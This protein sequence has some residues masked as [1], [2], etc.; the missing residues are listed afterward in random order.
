M[1]T[2]FGKALKRARIDA[3]LRL[4]ALGDA[5]GYSEAH[6]A[7]LEKDQRIASPDVVAERFLPALKLAVDS[8][9][10]CELVALAQHS[11]RTRADKRIARLDASVSRL[12]TLQTRFIGRARES[13][14]LRHLLNGASRLITLCGPGG[15]G[16]TRLAIEVAQGLQEEQT[17]PDGISFVE[18]ATLTADTQIEAAL[19][20]ALA[21]PIATRDLHP[22][23]Y[24]R[25]RHALI[26]F[27]NCEQVLDS[28]RAL[29]TR[30]QSTC[31]RVVVL[32]TSRERLNVAHET[33]FDVP[34]LSPG[35]AT[36]LYTDRVQT[37]MAL[38]DR[39]ELEIE[40]VRALCNHL[41][42][43]PLAIELAASRSKTLSPQQ[44]LA[45]IGDNRFNVLSDG[46]RSA[47]Q[48]HQTLHNLIDWSFNLL[49]A[50]E[51]MLLRRL[52]VFSGGWTIEAV[53]AICAD[54]LLKRN[55]IVHL[56]MQL[57]D[58]SLVVIDA[59][60]AT[61]RFTLL[62]SI[63]AYAKD[64]LSTGDEYRQ[65]RAR[66]LA[67]CVQLC[68]QAE[69]H[70]RFSQQKVWR[71]R[72]RLDHENISVALAWAA[73]ANGQALGAKILID[74]FWYWFETVHWDDYMRWLRIMILD[75]TRSEPHATAV[76]L[77]NMSRML[78]NQGNWE[79]AEA[80]GREGLKIARKLG[81]YSVCTC[82]LI[83]L[84]WVTHDR[85]RGLNVVRQAVRLA[86]QHALR[87]ELSTALLS[88][89]SQLGLLGR[90]AQAITVFEE[91]I[92]IARETDDL[93]TLT[94]ALFELCKMHAAQK[95]FAAAR[96]AAEEA[97]HNCEVGTPSHTRTRALLAVG[98]LA[99]DQG[100]TVRAVQVIDE[101][102]E[103]YALL[104]HASLLAEF[105]VLASTLAMRSAQCHSA[106]QLLAGAEVMLSSMR[107]YQTWNDRA[108]VDTL[109][110]DL[111]ATQDAALVNAAWRAGAQLSAEACIALAHVVIV[112]LVTHDDAHETLSLESAW[113]EKEDSHAQ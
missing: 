75:Q 33:T 96:A 66:H 71:E 69:P 93:G 89:G 106:I 64:A 40:S 28:V 41:D 8:T 65:T 58:K 100:D 101:A 4:R 81:D 107:I 88:E 61:Q 22:V 59:R 3:G 45:L 104:G 78:A 29:V 51:R 90:S 9:S 32:L 11:V 55:D 72:L 82:T 63:R 53:E 44:M 37:G 35:D 92:S 68:A 70:L 84:S 50:A 83:M 19:A 111:L 54:D 86:R 38:H 20:S 49:S 91:C 79:Q 43:L 112:T 14:R 12:P 18:L 103:L 48:R 6:I 56:L 108:R 105:L 73:A 76:A 85:V 23:D 95:D 21:V 10:G 25:E 39:G 16:K 57:I 31:P 60:L 24:L 34:V 2:T 7:R 36:S 98:R 17:F 113:P 62:E 87:W 110:Q 42:R 97:L 26:I 109:H 46:N 77:L 80:A 13:A 27:D 1:M 94:T 52:S 30:I 47:D 15:V 5:V 99:I 102:I 67:Y 74:T